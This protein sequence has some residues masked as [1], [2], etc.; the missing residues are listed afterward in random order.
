M[1]KRFASNVFCLEL[2]HFITQ[3]PN[4]LAE[5]ILTIVKIIVTSFVIHIMITKGLA[6]DTVNYLH[7]IHTNQIGL[8]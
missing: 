3:K 2:Q 1:A 8:Q 7:H 5:T 6:K 4:L